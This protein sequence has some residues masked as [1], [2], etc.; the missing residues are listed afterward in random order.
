MLPKQAERC[1]CVCVCACVVVKIGKL[2]RAPLFVFFIINERPQ[3]VILR[4]WKKKKT[5]KKGVLFS[6]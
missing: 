4:L 2:N 5:A 6:L 1:Q 3:T